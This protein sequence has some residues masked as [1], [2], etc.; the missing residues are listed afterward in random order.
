MGDQSNGA[1]WSGTEALA[2]AVQQRVRP[3]TDRLVRTILEQ[4][5]NPCSVKVSAIGSSDEIT[6]IEGLPATVGRTSTRCRR[7]GSR[8]TSR[9]AV[10]VNRARS[11][12][13]WRRSSRLVQRGSEDQ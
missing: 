13:P 9:S 3:L 4:N 12:L 11:W 7:L 6:T 1:G 2:E 5:L 10:T 8:S